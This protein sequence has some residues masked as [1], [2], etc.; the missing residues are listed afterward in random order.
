MALVL[1]G[2]TGR[3]K[4]MDTGANV[5]WKEYELTATTFADALSDTQAILALLTPLTTA[6]VERYSVNTVFAEDAW[7]WPQNTQV[8]NI[9]EI[10]VVLAEGIGQTEQIQI[11]APVAAMFQTTV[12]KGSNVVNIAY[13]PL[14]AYVGIYESGTG[15]ATISDGEFVAATN[16]IASGKRVHRKSR[17]G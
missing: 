5:S 17:R 9:A 12:G 2:Y 13:A 1:S 8:E 4:L 10:T 16:N 11:P 7:V 3:I 6:N 14:V 15:Y